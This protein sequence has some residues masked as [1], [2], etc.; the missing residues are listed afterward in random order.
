M[1]GVFTRLAKG[2]K[3]IEEGIKKESG[4][5]E[6]FMMHTIFG[7]LSCCPSNIGTGMRGSVHIVVP[8]LIA[9][10]GF[11]AIDKMCRERNC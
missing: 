2:V 9:S 1:L 5:E 11:E 8:K 3:L 4:V 6:A 10:I 7:S